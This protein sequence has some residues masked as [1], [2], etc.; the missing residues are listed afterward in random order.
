MEEG[1]IGIFTFIW[2]SVENYFLY[3]LLFSCPG[4]EWD[5]LWYIW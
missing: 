2:C 1:A 3:P 4:T 5:H